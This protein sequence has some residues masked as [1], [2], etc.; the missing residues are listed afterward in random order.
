MRMETTSPKEY[1]L[2]ERAAD[3]LKLAD[4]GRESLIE[5]LDLEQPERPELLENIQPLANPLSLQS[6]MYP[7][8]AVWGKEDPRLFQRLLKAFWALAGRWC[9]CPR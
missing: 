4:R 2:A 9:T 3:V 7:L 1:V 5:Y 6:E 8:A